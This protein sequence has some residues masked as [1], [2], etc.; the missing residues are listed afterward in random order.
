[1]AHNCFFRKKEP[2]KPAPK[3]N[4]SNKVN[5]IE[6]NPTSFRLASSSHLVN[7]LTASTDWYLDSGANI[8]VCND[9][10]SFSNYQESRGGSISLADDSTNSI[11]GSGRIELTMCM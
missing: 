1:M 3:G 4:G 8:H 5:M 6:M 10:S 9:R 11:I 2:A 7:S